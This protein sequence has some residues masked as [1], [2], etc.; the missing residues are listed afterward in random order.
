[1]RENITDKGRYSMKAE[2]IMVQ[3]EENF[4]GHE[5][6]E[7]IVEMDGDIMIHMK[8][9]K[10]C[11]AYREEGICKCKL[12]GPDKHPEN[13]RV[14]I[15]KAMESMTKGYCPCNQE[16]VEKED[17]YCHGWE[18]TREEIISTIVEE[19]ENND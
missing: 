9:L 5:E 14:N 17:T 16:G 2:D 15:I 10:G 18:K 6:I 13:K 1:M 8:P 19:A 11:K 12:Y 7:K 4:F 3:L